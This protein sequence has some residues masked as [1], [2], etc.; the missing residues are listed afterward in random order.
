MRLPAPLTSGGGALLLPLS[1]LSLA[2]RL[3]VT[4]PDAPPAADGPEPVA[5][6]TQDADAE[7]E[8]LAARLVTADQDERRQLSVA[9]HDGPLGSLSGIALIQDAALAAARSGR[10]QEVVALLEHVQE[11]TRETMQALRDLSSA[12]EPVILRDASLEDALHALSQQLERAEGITLDLDVEA[13]GL[14]SEKAQVALYQ[15][16]REAVGQ[17]ARRGPSRITVSITRGEG[18]E[19]I[20]TVRD[21]GVRERR[22]ANGGAVGELARFLSGRVEVETGDDGTAVTVS[23]P[24]YAAALG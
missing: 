8:R 18:G 6:V 20:T 24:A 10:P 9:L 11:R 22:L 15:T 4:A 16:I 21:D 3:R 2:G 13:G 5:G 1:L 12:L 23:I 7:R 19:I 17:A 14:L